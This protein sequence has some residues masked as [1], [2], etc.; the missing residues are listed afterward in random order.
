MDF[1]DKAEY[2]GYMSKGLGIVQKKVLLLLQAGIVLGLAYTSQRQLR[3]LKELDKEWKKINRQALHQAIRS[4]Y[5]SQLVT[6]RELEKGKVEMILSKQGKQKAISF[7]LD[8]LSIKKPVRWD[9]R[10]R[11]VAFDIPK[12]KK[13]ARDALR[14]HLRRLGFHPLQK[15][16]FVFP[17]PCEDELDF[18]IEYYD[19]RP[20]V[21][22]ITAQ[23]TDNALHLKNIFHL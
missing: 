13:K 18:L 22:L 8:D 10:W 7:K 17:H 20:C 9:G 16:L 3:V 5:Q 14:F 12:E 21:R 15:S 11:L 4:L 6:I 1:Q 19:L 23:D 2:N